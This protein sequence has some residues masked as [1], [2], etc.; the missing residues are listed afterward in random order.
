MRNNK[1]VLHAIFLLSYLLLIASCSPIV[2]AVDHRKMKTLVVFPLINNT[3]HNIIV[4]DFINPKDYILSTGRI[5]KECIF[6]YANDSNEK[7]VT[8]EELNLIKN[9][10]FLSRLKNMQYDLSVIPYIESFEKDLAN[11]RR[12]IY[13]SMLLYDNKAGKIINDNSVVYGS[14]RGIIGGQLEA[15]NEKYENE[16]ELKNVFGLG[17][18]GKVIPD[19]DLEAQIVNLLLK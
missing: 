7:S 10:H 1:N 14:W 15:I 12:N 19:M 18:V 3:D 9:S 11:S 8:K 2:T 4:P 6:V 16:H 17:A 13:V 5:L